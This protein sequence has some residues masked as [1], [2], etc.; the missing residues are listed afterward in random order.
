M[1]P[2]T[3]RLA[4]LRRVERVATMVGHIDEQRILGSLGM[5]WLRSERRAALDAG[6]RRADVDAATM[7][8]MVAGRAPDAEPISDPLT[9]R[10]CRSCYGEGTAGDRYGAGRCPACG[11]AGVEVSVD[12]D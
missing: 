1:T 2:P 7:D 11:G 10:V 3:V 8:G 9:E 6:C 4:H 5:T 12:A